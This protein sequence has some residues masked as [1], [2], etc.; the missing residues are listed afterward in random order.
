M[1]LTLHELFIVFKILGMR[2]E[3]MLDKVKAYL[4]ASLIFIHDCVHIVSM[5]RS[6]DTGT[7]NYI[8]TTP[9]VWIGKEIHF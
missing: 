8:R 9:I 7:L 2:I 5:S 6:C 3:F 4:L 1:L